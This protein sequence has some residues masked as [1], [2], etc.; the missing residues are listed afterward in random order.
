MEANVSYITI[1]RRT[2]QQETGGAKIWHFIVDFTVG[3]SVI[4]FGGLC[5]DKDK[6]VVKIE[7]KKGIKCEVVAASKVKLSLETIMDFVD[8]YQASHPSYALNPNTSKGESN[9][10]Q[11]GLDIA[12]KFMPEKCIKLV[13]GSMNTLKQVLHAKKY[14]LALSSLAGGVASGVASIFSS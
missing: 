7:D 5:E 11:F 10:Q 12:E 9:C 1:Q 14:D 6:F 2:V 3:E 13:K 4:S 8:K